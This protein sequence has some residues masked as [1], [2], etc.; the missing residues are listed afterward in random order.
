MII[1]LYES[2]INEDHTTSAGRKIG[3][4]R[5][6]GDGTRGKVV[7]NTNCNK[8][9]EVRDKNHCLYNNTLIFDEMMRRSFEITLSEGTYITTGGGWDGE[10]H[11][12]SGRTLKP[13]LRET[14]ENLVQYC[15]VIMRLVPI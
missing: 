14:M 8:I 11:S 9:R 4:V 7:Y 13:W 5:F 12:T 10:T 3:E 6:D 15:P 2:I 1:D